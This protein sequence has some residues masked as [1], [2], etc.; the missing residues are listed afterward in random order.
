MSSSKMV[1]WKKRIW[2]MAQTRHINQHSHSQTVYT[3]RQTYQV[4]KEDCR[5]QLMS[6]DLKHTAHNRQLSVCEAGCRK[7][8]RVGITSMFM[9][10]AEQQS[11]WQWRQRPNQCQT[12]DPFLF[13]HFNYYSHMHNRLVP[14]RQRLLLVRANKRRHVNREKQVSTCE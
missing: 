3:N 1:K 7:R 5:K 10:R 2:V 9:S 14:T 4:I 6:S 8:G 13:S 11:S 12:T